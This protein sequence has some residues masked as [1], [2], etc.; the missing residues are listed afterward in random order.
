MIQKPEELLKQ[1]KG[2][3]QSFCILLCG[4]ME[5]IKVP[6]HILAV[7]NP[8][9]RHAVCLVLVPDDIDITKGHHKGKFKFLSITKDSKAFKVIRTC[10]APLL[11]LSPIAR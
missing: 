6:S 7:G 3:C 10:C 9:S 4:I 1:G 11:H 2:N 5:A 8:G